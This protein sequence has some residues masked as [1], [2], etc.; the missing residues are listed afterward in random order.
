M[1]NEKSKKRKTHPFELFFRLNFTRNLR[2]RC[3][4]KLDQISYPKQKL[5]DRKDRISHRSTDHRFFD[6][7]CGTLKKK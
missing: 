7:S 5:T 1:F 2:Q 6:H 3:I 4:A